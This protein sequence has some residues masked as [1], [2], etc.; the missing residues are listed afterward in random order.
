MELDILR[1]IQTTAS[2]ALD[3]IAQA[4]TFCGE[5]VFLILAIAL[6]YWTIDKNKGES[7]ILSVLTT[8]FFY[9]TVKG[10]VRR[11]RP[12]GAEGIRSLRV[13]TATGTSFPS[14]HT[15]NAAAF[16]TALAV[17]FKKR[18]LYILSAILIVL[19]GLSRLYLG[20]H[21]PS[22]VLVGAV[23]GICI[24]LI[25]SR[26]SYYNVKEKTTA[27]VIVAIASVI[28][29]LA[30]GE[31]DMIKSAG[32]AVGTAIALP[33]EHRFIKFSTG[34]VLWKNIV[35][36][37]VGAALVAAAYLGLKYVL[38]EDGIW[39]FVRY[40]AVTLDMM[41]LCPWVFVKCKL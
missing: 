38:P 32:L 9:N 10:I 8:L 24:S 16:F 18:P 12:I 30:L 23:L 36:F 11:E 37:L 41:L 17:E 6:V 13:E 26:L 5:S 4:I 27:F 29:A 40:C 33:L 39:M 7:I 28:A 15:S 22:D 19:V 25:L 34:R 35:R 14:G 21:W 2:P 31:S 1:A 20:V 3:T